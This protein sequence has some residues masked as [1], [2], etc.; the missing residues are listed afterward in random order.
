VGGAGRVG[1]TTRFLALEP[2]LELGED[3]IDRV[4]HLSVFGQAVPPTR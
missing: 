1:S 2:I 3:S 4:V